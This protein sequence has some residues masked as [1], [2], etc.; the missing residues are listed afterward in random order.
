MSLNFDYLLNIKKCDYVFVGNFPMLKNV[1]LHKDTKKNL[2][3]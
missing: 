2:Y 3:V 1:F